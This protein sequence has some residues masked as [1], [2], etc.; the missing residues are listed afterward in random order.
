[1][2]VIIF[3]IT[4]TITIIFTGCGSSEK[5]EITENNSSEEV[6]EDD[7][8]LIIEYE[9][10][11]KEYLPNMEILAK[12][13]A[14]LD[15]DNEEDMVIIYVDPA[16]TTRSNICFI[17]KYGSHG[18]DFSSDEFGAVFAND[19]ES[20]KILENPTR[21]CVFLREINTNDIYEY[22]ITMETDKDINL[23]NFIIENFLIESGKTAN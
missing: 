8:S 3:I 22:H 9:N 5:R 4:I 17:T 18:L 2:M 14:D 13:M 7:S 1:M 21:V 6:K 12:E 20:L 23:T 16:E 11:F 15:N 19:A 10:R